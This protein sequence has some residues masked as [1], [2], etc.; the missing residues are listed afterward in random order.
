MEQCFFAD[1]SSS[2]T[3]LIFF[4]STVDTRNKVQY[5]NDLHDVDDSDRCSDTLL[6]EL[7]PVRDELSDVIFSDVACLSTTM[8]VT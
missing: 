6:A 2:G 7:I 3:F 1:H 4:L 5:N 8:C